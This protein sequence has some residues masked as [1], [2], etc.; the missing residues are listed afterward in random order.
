[1][2]R[3]VFQDPTSPTSSN[4]KQQE[5]KNQHQ[6]PQ[7]QAIPKTVPHL[8][9]STDSFVRVDGFFQLRNNQLRSAHGLSTKLG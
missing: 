1:V 6:H 8:I 7:L 3:K 9:F 4:F 2:K 5:L